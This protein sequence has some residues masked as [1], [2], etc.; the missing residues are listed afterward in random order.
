MSD[1]LGRNKLKNDH[2]GGQILSKAALK[3]TDG[4]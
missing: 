1:K 3:K 4:S 2:F